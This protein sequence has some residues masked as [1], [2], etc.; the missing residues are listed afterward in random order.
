MS[1]ITNPNT[2]TPAARINW[3][4]PTA[5]VILDGPNQLVA[6]NLEPVAAAMLRDL[7]RVLDE[8]DL[9]RVA[10]GKLRATHPSA[11]LD[12][13]AIAYMNT[14][15]RRL[16]RAGVLTITLD[17]AQAEALAGELDAAGV[18]RTACRHCGVLVDD[19]LGDAVCA[20][21]DEAGRR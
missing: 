9:T 21:C 18:E 19:V 6:L 10:W 17:Q 20:S 8:Q 5:D 13:D 14:V 11:L 2:A 1:T 3:N 7:L 16:S 12:G 15:V 4:P